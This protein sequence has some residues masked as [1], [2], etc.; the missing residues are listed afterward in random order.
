[1]FILGNV[2]C[3]LG[4]D[5]KM[6]NNMF[7][8]RHNKLVRIPFKHGLV[9]VKAYVNVLS[10]GEVVIYLMLGQT[11][12]KE[13]MQRYGMLCVMQVV[14]GAKPQKDP[15]FANPFECVRQVL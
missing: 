1:M 9:C 11:W 7:I 5:F 8:K 3:I 2:E 12:K 4:V 6:K 13:Y 15:N 10:E 14:V